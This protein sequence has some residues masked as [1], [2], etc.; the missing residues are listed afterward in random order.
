MMPGLASTH[1]GCW[2]A[3]AGRRSLRS[4]PAFTP[5][6]LGDFAPSPRLVCTES[7]TRVHPDRDSRDQSHSL[8]R[9]TLNNVRQVP[10]ITSHT[11][12]Y[13][14]VQCSSGM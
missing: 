14:N 11:I 6:R 4:G 9:N 7:A 8:R 10:M 3:Q 5:G 2:S 1:V 12:G 13:P